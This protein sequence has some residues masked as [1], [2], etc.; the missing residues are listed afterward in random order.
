MVGV[1]PKRREEA[2][3]DQGEDEDDR[4][5]EPP[6]RGGLPG[7]CGPER[8]VRAVAVAAKSRIPIVSTALSRRMNC[9]PARDQK[10]G[11]P[12]G[13]FRL[14]GVEDMV[15]DHQRG[16]A[17]S[18]KL[19]LELAVARIG[20]DR[21]VERA[22]PATT[23]PLP[24][25]GVR[26]G[27]M[28]E[29]LVPEGGFAPRWPG[30]KRMCPWAARR[31]QVPRRARNTARAGVPVPRP[32][33]GSAGERPGDSL[34]LR[35]WPSERMVLPVNRTK[36]AKNTPEHTDDQRLPTRGLHQGYPGPNLQ[37][38]SVHRCTPGE[39]AGEKASSGIEMRRRLV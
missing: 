27:A 34:H 10:L 6:R 1:Y 35:R 13:M 26:R 12:E 15:S 3:R 28:F 20:D 2:G 29:P 7:D 11:F 36:M 38:S 4:A 19:D 5:A 22:Q 25:C 17:A 30:R 8:P 33:T 32:S 37:E 14:I 21:E 39:S 16:G 18:V 23:R 31:C 24:T 9:N